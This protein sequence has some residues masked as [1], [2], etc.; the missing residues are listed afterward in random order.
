MHLQVGG[1]LEE[2][3]PLRLVFATVAAS[4]VDHASTFEA[5]N[6]VD[7][8]TRR[9]WVQAVDFSVQGMWLVGFGFTGLGY[10]IGVRGGGAIRRPPFSARYKNVSKSHNRSC[11]C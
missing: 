6:F 9:L 1:L 2:A 5:S 4:G 11:N 8:Y 7:G 3:F 10:S